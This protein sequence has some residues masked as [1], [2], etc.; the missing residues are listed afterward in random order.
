M[1]IL[2][3][4][5]F[6]NLFMFNLVNAQVIIGDDNFNNKNTIL[7]IINKNDNSQNSKGIKLPSV[8]NKTQLPL[9]N[10][11]EIDFFNDDSTMEGMIL[12]QED[13]KRIVVYDGEKWKETLFEDHNKYT[14]VSLDPKLSDS[15]YPSIGCFL[16]GCGSDD[17]PFD[18]TSNDSNLDELG[19]LNQKGTLNSADYS[20]FTFKESGLYRVIVSLGIKTSGIHVTPPVISIRALK[21]NY[22]LARKDIP[23]NESILITA[24]ANRT[25]TMEFVGKF[26]KDDLLKIQISSA[27]SILTVADTYQ[28][29][30]SKTTYLTIEKLF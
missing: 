23:L 25:G 8:K 3:N 16:V 29:R 14:N 30:P 20:N 9:Y 11:N 26:S 21:N 22:I 5:I 19:I 1:K 24:G 15:N 6:V 17:V 28:V 4:I 18:L 2:K 10:P 12:Y 7:G 13:I 27:I